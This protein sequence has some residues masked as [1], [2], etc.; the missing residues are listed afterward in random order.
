MYFMDPPPLPGMTTL[1]FFEPSLHVTKLTSTEKSGLSPLVRRTYA[2]EER[3][4]F[5][6]TILT[7]LVV[8]FPHGSTHWSP[9]L[10]HQW[11]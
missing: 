9:T 1:I 11:L 2:S 4:C 10:H 8:P 3:F 5:Y 7:S 6:F